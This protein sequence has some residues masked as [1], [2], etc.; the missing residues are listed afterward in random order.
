MTNE[1]LILNKLM[2]I[3][4]DLGSIKSIQDNLKEEMD[5]ITNRLTKIE[6]YFVNGAFLQI[7]KKQTAI[8]VGGIITAVAGY[9][10][11]GLT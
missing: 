10:G 5:V 1:Q 3:K 8:I 2:E 6:D 4:E 11:L 7:S 9:F